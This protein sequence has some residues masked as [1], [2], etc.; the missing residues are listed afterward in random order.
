MICPHCEKEIDDKLVG[1]YFA[2]K[3]GKKSAANRPSIYYKELAQKR[4]GKKV[5]DGF[6]K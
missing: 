2:R 4:W 1:Q 6:K 3:G 5:R